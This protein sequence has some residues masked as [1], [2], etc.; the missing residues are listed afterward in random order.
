MGN[1]IETL[2]TTGQSE[3]TYE[4]VTEFD[5]NWSA[6]F[7]IHIWTQRLLPLLFPISLT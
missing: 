5:S 1:R 3:I 4:N 7:D 2:K 6:C